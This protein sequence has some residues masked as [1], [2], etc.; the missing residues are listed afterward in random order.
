EKVRPGR[1]GEKDGAG[2]AFRA[3][4]NPGG[5]GRGGGTAGP[6]RA[7]STVGGAPGSAAGRTR[8]SGGIVRRAKSRIHGSPWTRRTGSAP[9]SQTSHAKTTAPTNTAARLIPPRRRRRSRR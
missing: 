6:S 5:R 1:G 8:G 3:E 4:R 7:I 9:V 2:G